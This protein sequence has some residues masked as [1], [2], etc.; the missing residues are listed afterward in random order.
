MDQIDKSWKGKHIIKLRDYREPSFI[1]QPDA[2]KLREQVE[3]WL[4]A[5]C[6]SERVNR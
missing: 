2:Q 3:P 6:Q 4:T 1:D 5:L